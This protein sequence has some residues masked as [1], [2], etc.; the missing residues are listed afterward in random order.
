M[1]FGCRFR[2]EEKRVKIGGLSIW[3]GGRQGDLYLFC[4]RLGC[5]IDLSRVALR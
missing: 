2:A 3:V 1:V 4:P 5:S